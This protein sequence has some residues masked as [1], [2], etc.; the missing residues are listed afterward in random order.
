MKTFKFSLWLTVNKSEHFHDL[1]A[2]SC[3]NVI[4]QR[5]VNCV[6]TLANSCR[7]KF[8]KLTVFLTEFWCK[9]WSFLVSFSQLFPVCGSRSQSGSDILKHC[10]LAP[11][12]MLH[13]PDP[14]AVMVQSEQS[15]YGRQTEIK[16]QS[17]TPR[18]RT[19]L[20]PVLIS[21]N[22]RFFTSVIALINCSKENSK[23]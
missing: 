15:S 17:E 3:A 11:L 7:G 16:S 4:Y 23:H 6:W 5:A 22:A 18:T 13:W 21:H 10:S 20:G 14:P 1:K 12:N 19:V 8:V 9:S 2:F